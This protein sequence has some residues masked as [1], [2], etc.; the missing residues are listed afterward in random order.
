MATM[1]ID[2][3]TAKGMLYYVSTYRHDVKRTKMHWDFQI[4]VLQLDFNGVM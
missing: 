1:P 2:L 4:C 3:V